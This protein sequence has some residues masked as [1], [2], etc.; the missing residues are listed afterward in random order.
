MKNPGYLTNGSI[1]I[2]KPSCEEGSNIVVTIVGRYEDLSNGIKYV[3]IITVL[4]PDDKSEITTRLKNG[5]KNFISFKLE[6]IVAI[7]GYVEDIENSEWVIT[8][9]INTMIEDGKVIK[10]DNTLDEAY[11]EN[12]YAK[13]RWLIYNTEIDQYTAKDWV[14]KITDRKSDIIKRFGIKESSLEMCKKK[15]L[16]FVDE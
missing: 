9:T 6:D 2:L 3:G 4:D 12:D 16:K 14:N 8:K 11:I 1:V 13:F 7:A 10:F 15:L 5:I